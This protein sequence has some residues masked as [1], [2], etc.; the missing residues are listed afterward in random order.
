MSILQ[1]NEF[2]LEDSLQRLVASNP[3]LVLNEIYSS[4]DIS[5]GRKL[6]LIGREIELS[7]GDDGGSR[8][9]DVLFVNDE[10]LPVLVEVKLAKNPEI[11]RKVIA[12]II[13]YATFAK[14]WNKDMLR[15]SFLKNNSDEEVRSKIDTDDFWD[16]VKS[17]LDSETYT[18]VI[19]ADKI[20]NELEQ[21][22]KFLDRKIPDI[23]V[24][25]IEINTYGDV[26]STKF[27]GNRS[28]RKIT[29]QKIEWNRNTL[30][31]RCAKVRPDLKDA[32]ERLVNFSEEISAKEKFITLNYGQGSVYASM[33]LSLESA[34][35]FQ[36]QNL[37]SDIALYVS[38]RY[39]AKIIGGEYTDELVAEMFT[40]TPTPIRIQRSKWYLNF[41]LSKLAQG[42]NLEYFISQCAEIVNAY[43]RHASSTPPP[44][45]NS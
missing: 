40:N 21:M 1:I 39:L 20:G 45:N 29:E 12:Q 7:K 28:S 25:G 6:Y 32:A 13:G 30:I 24:C 42:D 8:F 14:L 31:A 38:Y 4:D 3:D 18:L 26:Y 37:N 15:S 2:A 43:K 41:R 10:G 35:L 16:R 27:I 44:Q 36:M 33:A 11:V 17:H 9:L 5:G 23:K 34:W 19:A 22:I